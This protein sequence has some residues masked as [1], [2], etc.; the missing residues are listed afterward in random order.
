MPSERGLSLRGWESLK[1]EERKVLLD[2]LQRIESSLATE[3]LMAFGRASPAVFWQHVDGL[4]RVLELSK[5][6]KE[7]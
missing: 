2:S 1:D 7:S 3:L 4:R 5:I 6:V